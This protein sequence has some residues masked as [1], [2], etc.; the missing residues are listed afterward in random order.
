MQGEVRLAGEILSS[1]VS[2]HPLAFARPAACL[3]MKR[4]Y[5]MY[6][7]AAEKAKFLRAMMPLE[8]SQQRFCSR[9]CAWLPGR[10]SAEESPLTLLV[11][12]W[13]L[14]RKG[15]VP[16]LDDQTFESCAVQKTKGQRKPQPRR[17][18]ASSNSATEAWQTSYAQRQTARWGVVL[19]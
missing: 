19:K 6:G 8:R 13:W 1:Y 12:P 5:S 18:G 3:A 11:L 9:S 14:R 17:S 7:R 4:A 15:S 10:L 2:L 16:A